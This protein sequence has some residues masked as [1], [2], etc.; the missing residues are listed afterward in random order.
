MNEVLHMWTFK[1]STDSET[2][3]FG[4]VVFA[5]RFDQMRNQIR[6]YKKFQNMG[7]GIKKYLINKI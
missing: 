6:V 1:M 5:H 4:C 7:F 3:L 2:N